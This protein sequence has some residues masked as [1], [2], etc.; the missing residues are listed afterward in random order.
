MSDGSQSGLPSTDTQDHVE[1]ANDLIQEDR[2][3]TFCEVC[4]VLDIR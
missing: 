4:E 1:P 2:R 3:T